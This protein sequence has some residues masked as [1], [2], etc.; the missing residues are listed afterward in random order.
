[1]ASQ[2]ENCRSSFVAATHPRPSYPRTI[3]P[4][5]CSGLVLTTLAPA[6]PDNWSFSFFGRVASIAICP[7]RLNRSASIHQSMRYWGAG[8]SI[9][10]PDCATGVGSLASPAGVA[11]FLGTAQ[12]RLAVFVCV[13]RR[14]RS[15][16]SWQGRERG[17]IHA[18]AQLGSVRVMGGMVWQAHT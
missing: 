7:R 11:L 14:R 3:P 1:M 5:G 4:D 13:A 8:D 9:A 17:A 6:S 10:P 12:R 18:P 15:A 2:S 16:V